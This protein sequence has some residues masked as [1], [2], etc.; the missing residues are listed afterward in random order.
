MNSRSSRPLRA[1]NASRSLRRAVRPVDV[2]DDEQDRTRSH[3][4][5]RGVR[6]TPSKIRIWS[7]SCPLAGPGSIRRP[8]PTVPVRGGAA[9]A[10]SVRRRPRCV[11]WSTSRDRARSASTIG[12]NGRPSSPRAIEPPSRTS[13][14][15]SRRSCRGLGDEPALADPGLTTDQASTAVCPDATASAVATGASQLARSTDEDR[16]GQAS[17]HAADDTALLASPRARRA[18][19]AYGEGPVARRS[20]PLG[21]SAETPEMEAVR[22]PRPPAGKR[23]EAGD[24]TA[25]DTGPLLATGRAAR[26]SARWVMARSRSCSASQ[27]K[28]SGCMVTC[29]DSLSASS[30]FEVDCR[31]ARGGGG[32]RTSRGRPM[33]DGRDPSFRSLRRTRPFRAP[34]PPRYLASCSLGP[35]AGERVGVAA[36]RVDRRRARS[37]RPARPASRGR[38]S[39]ASRRGRRSSRRAAGRSPRRRTNTARSSAARRSRAAPAPRRGGG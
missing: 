11:S 24:P 35:P 14:P 20:Q 34:R 21:R 26:S 39:R 38:G 36:A 31:Q 22:P 29:R 12:P 1:R 13:Q 8:R 10:G 30:G 5:G 28:V 25:N 2:L 37:A 23:R 19:G 18:V 9:R 6:R 27:R 7:H 32:S 3:R 17:S 4:D 15:R 16:A 33:C